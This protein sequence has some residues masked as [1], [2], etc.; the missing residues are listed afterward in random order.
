[1]F[2]IEPLPLDSE[3]WE[4]D[5]VLITPHIANLD[6]NYWKNEISLFIDNLKRFSN[7]YDLRNVINLERGY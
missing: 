1:M 7:N 6:K 2:R 4:L 3:L 5:N